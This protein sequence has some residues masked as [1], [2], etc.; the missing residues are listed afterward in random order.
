[1]KSERS[2]CCFMALAE[3]MYVGMA[4]LIPRSHEVLC[5][6]ENFSL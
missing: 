2:I 4:G 5:H 3:A 6:P 1:M